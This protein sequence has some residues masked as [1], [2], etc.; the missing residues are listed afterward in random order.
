METSRR[1]DISRRR[2]RGFRRGSRWR[3]SSRFRR[4]QGGGEV[5]IRRRGDQCGGGGSKAAR[6][7]SPTCIQNIVVYEQPF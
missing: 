6:T 7:I 1:K 3:R 2:R 5:E 4:N